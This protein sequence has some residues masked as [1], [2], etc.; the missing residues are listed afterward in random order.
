MSKIICDVCGTSYPETANQCPICGCVRPADAATVKGDTNDVGRNVS[1]NYTYVKGGR[2][3][4]ANVK[5]R[6]QGKTVTTV[7]ASKSE[8]KPDKSQKSDAPLVIVVIALLLA[9]VAIVVY[10]AIHYFGPSLTGEN[11]EPVQTTQATV[12]TTEAT[13]ETTEATVA[14]VPCQEVSVSD[15]VITFDKA[16][17]ALLLNV[18]TQPV[19]TTDLITYSTSDEA[20]AVVTDD[21]KVVAVGAGEALITVTCGNASAQCRVICEIPEE[22][23][24]VTEATTY[25]ADALKLNREDFTLNGKGSTWTLYKGEIPAELITWTSDDEKVATFANGVVTAVGNGYTTVHAEYGDVKVDCIVRCN[26]AEAETTQTQ[27]PAATGAYKIST[28]DVTIKVG[29]TFNL[30]LSD[31]DGGAVAAEWLSADSSVCSVSGNAVT[32]AGVGQ[33]VVSVTING[34]TYSCIVR[35][36]SA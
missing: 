18:D 15:E 9:I 3:S 17:A 13:V 25:P 19:D 35:V 34:A 27:E 7:T 32:G 16:G 29:E 12:E 5:K 2:F 26:V 10:I 28:T 23:V 8:E 20:V 36:I 4:K 1:G 11:T 31:V 22:T 14:V 24:E 33:T 30:Q 6:T 21:G